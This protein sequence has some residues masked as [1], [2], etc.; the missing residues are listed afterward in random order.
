MALPF[1][2][3]AALGAAF[4]EAFAVLYSTVKDVITKTLAFKSILQQLK[5][6]LDVLDP[7][8]KDIQQSNRELGRSEKETHDLI[9]QMNKGEKLVS[10]YSNLTGW[11]HFVRYHY[12]NKLCSLDDALRR[13]F[14][15]HIPAWGL[16]NGIEVLRGVNHLC[17]QMNSAGINGV[18][19]CAVP[20]PP[21]FTVGLDVSW[22]ELK[23]ELLKK[24]VL[25]L[26]LTAPGGCG[27][28]TLVKMLC[29]DEDIKGTSSQFLLDC[30]LLKV[31]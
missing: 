10:K 21:D 14:Q 26:V 30:C 3:S 31:S 22:K 1:V 29:Q 16:R 19:P 24:E 20:E 8:V 9:Q 25:M 15:I 11:K 2:G 27:K 12:A 23:M 7:L 6:T 28:T 18:L 4:G 17:A 5:S 13:F